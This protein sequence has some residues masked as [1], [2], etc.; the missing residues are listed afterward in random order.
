MCAALG[1]ARACGPL[2]R[3]EAFLLRRARQ[4]PRPSA[5]TLSRLTAEIRAGSDPLGE[6]FCRVRPGTRRRSLGAF[7]TAEEIVTAMARWVLAR[8]PGTIVD[9]GCGSGRFAGA[10]HR[11]GFSG[12]PFAVDVDPL[13]TLMTRANLAVMGDRRTTVVHGDLLRFSLPDSRRGRTAFIGNPPYVRH[14]ALRPEV[15]RWARKTGDALGVLVS[16]LSGLHALFVLAIAQLSRPGDLGCLITAAEWL[17]VGYGSALRQLFAH[18][19]G[20]VRLDIGDPRASAFGDAMS[21]AAIVSWEVA[22]SGA[23]SVRETRDLKTLRALTGG[24]VIS[25]DLLIRSPRW[26]D[27]L[28]PRSQ[29]DGLVPLGTYARVHRGIATGANSFFILSGD[30]AIIRE[31]EGHVRPCVTR[32]H[33]VI[34]SG[35][36]VRA[37]KLD[38]VLL[39]VQDAADHDRALRAY[40]TEGM[41]H[42]VHERYLCAHRNPWWRLGGGPPPPIV[43]TYMA[44]QAPMFALNP[45]RCRIVNVLHGIHF[46]EEV[47]ED[48]ATALVVWLNSHRDTLT[49]GRTY[50][51]GLRKFEPRELEAILVPPLHELAASRLK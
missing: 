42:R 12:E 27:L 50:H 28:R 18:H 24:R 37:D 45:D 33:Q 5:D 17:D 22:Y 51:G 39:V 38:H 21:T 48:I 19:L 25:R 4:L 32:A 3:A 14:H 49:G 20:C 10:V 13:A 8:D 40:L 11:L 6:A 43:A 2:S 46:R 36:I 41:R 9:V 47:D 35:G 7:Y 31:L 34:S 16:G 23:I 30:E 15:K 29:R 1:A 26:R 44:R